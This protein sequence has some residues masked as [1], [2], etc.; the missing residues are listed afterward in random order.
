MKVFKCLNEFKYHSRHSYITL[1]LFKDLQVFLIRLPHLFDHI[2]LLLKKILVP[3]PNFCDNVITLIDSIPS[4][5]AVRLLRRFNDEILSFPLE[6]LADFLGLVKRITFET[7]IPPTKLIKAILRFIRCST[8]C[9]DGNWEIGNQ[10]LL[11]SR[12]ILIKHQT[13]SVF[14]PLCD[15]LSFLALNFSDIDIRD[16]AH[17]YYQLLTHIPGEK[18]RIILRSHKDGQSAHDSVTIDSAPPVLAIEQ[19]ND[20]SHKNFL[21]LVRLNPEFNYNSLVNLDEENNSQPSSQMSAPLNQFNLESYFNNIETNTFPIELQFYLKYK[22]SPVTTSVSEPIARTFPSKLYAL[23]LQFSNSSV[24][25]PIKDVHIPFLSQGHQEEIKEEFPYVYK[26]SIKIDFIIPLPTSFDITA[27]YNNEEGIGEEGK[28]DTLVLRLND[29][30]SP[31]VIPKDVSMPKE[32][33]LRTLFSSLW[34]K[35]DLDITNDLSNG[36]RRLGARSVKFIEVYSSHVLSRLSTSLRPYLISP[37]DLYEHPFCGE[38]EEKS[39]S[40]IKSTDLADIESTPPIPVIVFMAPK[41]HLLMQFFVNEKATLVK[42]VSDYW[43]IMSYIDNY[44]ENI[45]RI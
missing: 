40:N 29:I 24:C 8:V 1:A 37:R 44:L 45:F 38:Q 26:I 17:F 20:H 34:N 33:Y 27:H 25:A 18:I 3:H 10:L 16:R 32:T 2:Y 35:I 31:V 11:I 14:K 4:N 23:V 12:T 19:Q 30:L 36:K 6:K 43:R 21:T 42:I 41:Y 13:N 39:E 28:I 22:D 9:R 7:S 15:L 5:I